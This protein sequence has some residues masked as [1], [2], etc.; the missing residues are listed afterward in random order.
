[1][2]TV[3]TRYAADFDADGRSPV[4]LGVGIG[5][6]EFTA[7]DFTMVEQALREMGSPVLIRAVER[8]QDQPVPSVKPDS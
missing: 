7:Y 1:M 3:H 4:D 8:R 6:N 2:N 5:P